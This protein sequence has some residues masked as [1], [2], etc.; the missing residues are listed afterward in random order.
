M[1]KVCR[2]EEIKFF[3]SV[4]KKMFLKSGGVK[5]NH[6]NMMLHNG[7]IPSYHESENEGTCFFLVI[8]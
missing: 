6:K 3:N 4:S 2:F 5:S 1:L 7:R 8:L